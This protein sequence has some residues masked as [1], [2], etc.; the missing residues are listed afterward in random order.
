[1]GRLIE[2]FIQDGH[3]KCVENQGILLNMNAIFSMRDKEKMAHKINISLRHYFV[4]KNTER[5][6][7]ID[8]L[9]RD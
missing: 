5:C 2:G 7:T 8:E 4:T 3:L 9:E 6:L 1:M